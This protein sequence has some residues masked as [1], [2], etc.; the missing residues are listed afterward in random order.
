[1]GKMNREKYIVQSDLL[2]DNY[3]PSQIHIQSTDVHRTIQ[4]SY[5]EMM[6]LYP[7]EASTF[8]HLSDGEIK[9]L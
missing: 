2:D 9:S 1:M 7:P 6:G 4:S 3:L 8:Q 5:S